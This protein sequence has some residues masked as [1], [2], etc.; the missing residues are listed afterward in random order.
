[1]DIM[2]FILRNVVISNVIGIGVV[3]NNCLHLSHK[4]HYSCDLKVWINY[5]NLDYMR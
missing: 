2:R 1:M 5:N 3:G 4:A